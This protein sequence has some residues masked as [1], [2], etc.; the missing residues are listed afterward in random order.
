[1]AKTWKSLQVTRQHLVSPK[2]AN[3]TDEQKK[4]VDHYY[5]DFRDEWTTDE[6]FDKIMNIKLRECEICGHDVL[7]GKSCPGILP[8]NTLKDV[9]NPTK[10]QLA[11]YENYC[12]V[13]AKA[14]TERDNSYLVERNKTEKMRKIASERMRGGAA[15]EMSRMLHKKYDGVRLCKTCGKEA[16]HLLGWGCLNCHNTSELMVNATRNRNLK[17][18]QDPEYAKRMTEVLRNNNKIRARN[19]I[20]KRAK[21]KVNKKKKIIIDDDFRYKVEDKSNNKVKDQLKNKIKN[22][23]SS[24]K[25]KNESKKKN[26]SKLVR[27]RRRKIIAENDCKLHINCKDMIYDKNENRYICWDCKKDEILNTESIQEI[28]DFGYEIIPT[29]YDGSDIWYNRHKFEGGLA[30]DKNVK[31]FS[32]VKFYIDAYAASRP[33]VAGKSGSLLVN[34]RG[35]DVIFSIATK[36]GPARRFLK[37]ERLSWDTSI[38]AIK[39][40]DLEKDAYKFEEETAK[41]FNLF[42]S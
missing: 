26:K 33:L 24:N 3:L 20:S 22:K 41:H 4:L 13:M 30:Y 34:K 40:F 14:A 2:N 23:V 27:P 16:Y 6:I 8:T 15:A 36:D 25:V 39:K 11:H 10:F 17:N 38:I 29:F 19:A 18:W 1:M 28:I 37:R 35:T 31:W 9:E 5:Y 42:Y 12:N 21:N 32:Y 7:I